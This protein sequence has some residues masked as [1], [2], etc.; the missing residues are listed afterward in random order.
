MAVRLHAR[1]LD[2]IHGAAAVGWEAYGSSPSW[3]VAG[4]ACTVA[5]PGG[6]HDTFQCGFTTPPSMARPER[7]HGGRGAVGPV[8][9][10]PASP[11]PRNEQHDA[12]TAC[13]RRST[14]GT[15][16]RGLA[17]GRLRARG[18]PRLGAV[19]RTTRFAATARLAR[20]QCQ[21]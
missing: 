12:R 7:A 9:A 8:S 5:G 11:G 17:V 13:S 21:H 20:R 16:P 14:H 4:K 1:R 2:L 15:G 10:G 19:D 6:L 18:E 3:Q